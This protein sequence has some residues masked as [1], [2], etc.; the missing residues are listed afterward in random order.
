MEEECAHPEPETCQIAQV[1]DTVQKRDV[2][3]GEVVKQ[4]STDFDSSRWYFDTGTNAHITACKAY[5]TTL[6][7]MDD[8]DW[9]PQISG[10][11]DGI[12]A[13]AEGFGTIMLAVMIDEQMTLVLVEN[14]LHV[15]SAGCNLFSPGLALDQGFQLSWEP[16]TIMFGMTKDSMEVIRT[17]HE[18][19]LWTFTDH[20][21]GCDISKSTKISTEN[22]VYA[23][24]AVTDGVEDI[25]VWHERLG[26]TCSEYI[27]LMVDRGMAKG[28]I[29]KRRGKV[30]CAD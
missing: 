4:V 20:N 17:T 25:G 19:H 29:L 28:I 1:N 10:F 18:L 12:G 16:N 24:F 27:R 6:Q 7:S 22:Q 8:C 23:N 9:N 5:F 3:I 21:V 30:D 13:K 15:P 11:A 2:E 26:H 14:V